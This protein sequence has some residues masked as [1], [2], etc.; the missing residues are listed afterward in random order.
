MDA[1]GDAM[2]DGLTRHL[3]HGV[4]FGR[5][6]ATQAP[7]AEETIRTRLAARA[8][9]RTRWQ[10]LTG[11]QTDVYSSSQFMYAQ[12]GTLFAELFAVAFGGNDQWQ[13]QLQ[14]MRYA[15]HIGPLEGLPFVLS[16]TEANMSWHVDGGARS[17][18]D[19]VAYFVLG[20]TDAVSVVRVF[21]IDLVRHAAREAQE[22][23]NVPSEQRLRQ[24]LAAFDNKLDVVPVPSD[25]RVGIHRLEALPP[26][27]ESVL[28][29]DAVI[30][31]YAD[32]VACWQISARS[33]DVLV[34]DGSQLHSV[35]NV[36]SRA[37]PLDPQ[38][39]LAVN[40]RR[41]APRLVQRALTRRP[42][43]RFHDASVRCDECNVV[44]DDEEHGTVV[45]SQECT[46]GC[47]TWACLECA[48]RALPA[49]W[50]CRR[51]R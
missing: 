39:A 10:L 35:H 36:A 9:G 50:A 1:L 25:A 38:L 7:G 23:G 13:A 6:T 2:R 26:E 42:T 8:R 24:R 18:T 14:R 37:S 21:G 48:A 31:P 17:T 46:A 34:F 3:L 15:V 49:E 16:K 22:D 28:L 40:F 5:A 4:F 32:C 29:E 47:D 27:V 19:I 45:D 44:L 30:G 41:L 43:L 51:H 11:G 12:D 20:P 33:G